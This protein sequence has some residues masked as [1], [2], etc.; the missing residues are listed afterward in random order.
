[1]FQSLVNYINAIYNSFFD[2]ARW[3]ISTL[4]EVFKTIWIYAIEFVRDAISWLHD[5]LPQGARDILDSLTL[6]PLA[7]AYNL[8]TFAFPIHATLGI[9]VSAYSACGVIRLIRWALG[10]APALNAG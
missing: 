8:V 5:A 4:L 10:F 2:F 7:D 1:M 6:A 3:I 9:I